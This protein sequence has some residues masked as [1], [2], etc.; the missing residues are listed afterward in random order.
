VSI[1]CCFSPPRLFF[2]ASKQLTNVAEVVDRHAAHVHRH[3]LPS[4]AGLER[5]LGPRHRVVQRQRRR[6]PRAAGGIVG[7]GRGR[8]GQLAGRGAS[9]VHRCCCCRLRAS[10]CGGNHGILPARRRRGRRDGCESLESRRRRRRQARR[11]QR[12]TWP[13]PP[14]SQN[15]A[16]RHEHAREGARVASRGVEHRHEM[17]TGRG[18]RALAR[19]RSVAEICELDFQ[20]SFFF[21]PLLRRKKASTPH[22][23]KRNRSLSASSLLLVS[24]FLHLQRS[25]RPR[26]LSSN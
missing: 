22:S 15:K 4:G 11:R 18:E 17:R 3:G 12:R 21:F 1:C 7:E 2:P 5:A 20:N 9:R 10:S 8:R 13:V 24:R 19:K 14:V 25:L 26:S 16:P 23:K 6:L